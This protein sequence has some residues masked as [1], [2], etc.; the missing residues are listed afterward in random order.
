M[1]VPLPRTETAL[2]DCRA[3]LAAVASIHPSLDTAAIGS[4]LAGHAAVLL[5]AE[6]ES[7][8]AAFFDE[9]IDSSTCE[10]NVKALART[11]KW[12]LDSA[13]YAD[14][15]GAMARFGDTIRDQFKV[16]VIATSG[17][18]GVASLGTVVGMRNAT[19]HSIPPPV[20]FRDVE[21]ATNAAKEILQ[22]A[23]SALALS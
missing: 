16:D 8:M 17:E 12:T 2:A 19:S 1:A 22:A 20:T 6:I 4:Y 21:D 10:P 14:I 7:T 5:C 15:V 23:R 11:R 9:I 13:K 3:H 18:R